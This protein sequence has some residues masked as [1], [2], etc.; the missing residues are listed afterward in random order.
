MILYCTF[1]KRKRESAVKET[2][3]NECDKLELKNYKELKNFVEWFLAKQMYSSVPIQLQQKT[4][5][6][7]SP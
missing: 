3:N 7:Q 4:T 2:E 5:K 1:R 6:L